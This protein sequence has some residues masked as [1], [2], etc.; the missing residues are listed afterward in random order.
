MASPSKPAI[1]MAASEALPFAKTGG[2]GDVMGSLPKHLAELGVPVRVVIPFYPGVEERGVSVDK[3]LSSLE[4]NMG[5]KSFNTDVYTSIL[6]NNYEVFLI[7]YDPFFHRKNLYGPPGT[8]YRDNPIRF[9]FFARAVVRLTEELPGRVDI[10]HC[11]DWQTGLIPLFLTRKGVKSLFT[12]HNLGYQG[13]FP[14]RVL[15]EIGLSRDHFHP[16]DLEFFGRINYLKAGIVWGDALS[17]VSPRYSREIQEAEYGFG[18]EG[19]L[20]KHSAK[21]QGILNG[22]D[23]TAWDPGTDPFLAAN[24]TREDLEGKNVCREELLEIFNLPEREKA[25]I[26]GIITRLV[27]QKGVDLILEALPAL[28]K[29]KLRL[30]V[31][32]TGQPEY[33]KA[34]KE[35][36]AVYPDLGVHIGYDEALAHKIEAGA[37]IYLMPSLYEPCGLN[38]IYSLRYGT[39]PVVR[40]TGGLKDTVTPF[41]RSTGEG[42]GFTFS[43]KSG[44]ALTAA[45]DKALVLWSEP[46]QW[47]KIVRNAMSV[48]YSWTR[49]AGQ[50]LQLYRNILASP[51]V[52]GPR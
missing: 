41:V 22:V 10:V 35:A 32:G 48:D 26:L 38:Q 16:E 51:A 49:S 39:I 9:A 42:V 24:Y 5:D 17:T 23:Y 31:L 7:R 8:D 46:G 40:E 50:Y 1:L 25:P 13:L 43:G 12:I 37:D 30:V 29:R 4:I 45:V 18:L 15:E 34:L 47:K 3:V 19:I 20:K 14:P 36:A 2:L 52:G 44:R 27:H 11:H 33:Q 6:N 28:M 21:L